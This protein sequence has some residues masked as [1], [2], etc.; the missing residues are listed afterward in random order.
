MSAPTSFNSRPVSFDFYHLDE[1]SR[2]FPQLLALLEN[3]DYIFVPSRRLFVNH[4]RL[5]EKYPLTAKYYEL[6]FSGKLG[7]TEIKKFQALPDESAEET[8]SV[9]DHPVVRI[10]QKKVAIS[11]KEYEELFNQP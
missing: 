2:L 4:L 8:W 10:Y 3:S 7:F 5:P 9:F 1:D 11:Q 6:L